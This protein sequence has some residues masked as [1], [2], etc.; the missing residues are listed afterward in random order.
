MKTRLLIIIAFVVGLGFV[1]IQESF[2]QSSTDNK[3]DL[4]LF[5]IDGFNIFTNSPHV[6]NISLDWNGDKLPSGTITFDSKVTDVIELHVPINMPRT[7]NLD[8]GTAALA[9]F[10]PNYQPFHIVQTRSDCF[11]IL[12][13][14]IKDTE[15]IEFDSISVAAGRLEQVTENVPKCIFVY[16]EYLIATSSINSSQKL[17]VSKTFSQ[18]MS[19]PSP[20]KQIKS[21]IQSQNVI[22]EANLEL[23]QKYDGSPACVKEQSI[24]KLKERGWGCLQ[25]CQTVVELSYCNDWCDKQELF[26]MGCTATLLDYLHENSNMFGEEYDFYTF[27]PQDAP[28]GVT[29]EKYEE[30]ADFIHIKR[31]TLDSEIPDL[32]KDL[33]EVVAFYAKYDDAQVSVREDHISYFAGSSDAAF[34]RMNV[35]YDENYELDHMEFNCYVDRVPQTE[36]A[37]TF[38]LKYLEKF[39]C[40][41]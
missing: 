28:N 40:K 2:A 41:K 11:D 16:N 17:D 39:D 10:Y 23:I 4:I 27:D 1:G 31:S 5:E 8:F 33:P 26:D 22:C 9:V 25:L 18:I 35:F 21:G 36:V 12:S 15:K 14:E 13:I 30:C 20:L 24:V 32:Y 34:I 38:I 29:E 3:T 37:E 6:T 19:M 7:T